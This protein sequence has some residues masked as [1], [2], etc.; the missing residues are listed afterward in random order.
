MNVSQ[1]LSIS[2]NTNTKTPDP[3]LAIAALHNLGFIVRLVHN[4]LDPFIPWNVLRTEAIRAALWMHSENGSKPVHI[5]QFLRAA[6]RL[7]EPIGE[8]YTGASSVATTNEALRG[9]DEINASEELYKL[10]RE[11]LNELE[12]IGDIVELPKGYWLPAPLRAVKMHYAK[13]WLIL[14]GL[15]RYCCSKKLQDLLETH[16][17]ARSVTQDPSTIGLPTRVLPLDV[18]CRI[19]REPLRDWTLQ[20]FRDLEMVPYEF[21]PQRPEMHIYVP[22][23]SK[24]LQYARWINQVPSLPGGRYLIRFN[25]GFTVVYHIAEIHGG[26]IQKLSKRSI[27]S[28][29]ARRLCYGVDLLQKCPVRVDAV[30]SNLWAYY[31]LTSELPQPELQFLTAVGELQLDTKGKYY[32]R[33]WKVYKEVIGEIEE[34]FH[35]LGIDLRFKS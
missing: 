12:L 19:P 14:G 29:E 2:Y 24:G 16:G 18:W 8:E 11:D 35:N 6:Q 31:T 5:N 20:T 25:F 22:H 23:P 27:Q 3:Q 15:P 33:R 21:E 30:Y 17:V 10:Y 9:V 4:Q 26:E 32:P 34:I 1:K 13:R 7:L 28:K